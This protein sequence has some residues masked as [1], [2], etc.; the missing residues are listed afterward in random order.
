MPEVVSAAFGISREPVPL[1][2]GKGGTWRAGDVVL[3]PV[4]YLPE[5]LWR[6]EVLDALPEPDGFRIA[7]PLRT[8]D[9]A[10]VAHGWEAG[11]LLAG[12]PDVGRPDDAIR[13]GAAFHEAVAGLRRPG[14]LDVRD[15]PWSYADRVA[16]EELPATPS[17]LLLPLLEARRPVSLEAQAVHGDLAGNVLFADGLPPAVIDWPVYWRP[18]VWASAVVVADALCWYG[19]GP[20]LVDRWAHL[21]GWRQMLIR[22]LIYRILSDDRIQTS[23]IRSATELTI[24]DGR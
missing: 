9:G 22:A 18:T 5:T 23:S 15:D 12:E 13:A 7:R 11:R 6:A 24:R 4:E 21:P 3:K 20:D 8:T 2:G 17:D 14:F 1:A 10:W 16:W 19:A